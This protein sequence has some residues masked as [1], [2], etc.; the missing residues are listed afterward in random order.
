LVVPRNDL[1]EGI[2]LRVGT[3]HHKIFGRAT[4]MLVHYSLL[5][6][7]T[8]GECGVQVLYW[9][10]FFVVASSVGTPQRVFYF[11]SFYFF[12]WLCASIL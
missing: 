3:I 4:T 10:L 2:V 1:V 12:F 11:L 5:G 8:F 6:G 7:V 9:W